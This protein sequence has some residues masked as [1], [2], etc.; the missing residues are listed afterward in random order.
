MSAGCAFETHS[1]GLG[2]GGLDAD[3]LAPSVGDAGVGTGGFDTTTPDTTT[4]DTTTPDTT[5]P[6]TTTPDTTTPDTTTSDTTTPDKL[7]PSISTDVVVVEP[8]CTPGTERSSCPGTSCDPVTLTCTTLMLA[9]RSTCETCFTDSNCAGVDHRCVWMTYQGEPIPDKRMGFCLQ[10]AEPVTV[11]GGYA[12]LP[13]FT[14]PLVNRESPSGGKNQSYCGIHEKL[15]TCFA[16]RAFHNGEA[17]PTGRDDECP[18]GGLCRAIASTG[19]KTE[20][21]CTYACTDVSECSSPGAKV[22]CAGFCGG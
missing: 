7:D 6:D 17:C 14:V 15:T 9:S 8:R 5:T 4:P 16:L 18:T 12:C 19:R 21:T 11:D 20:Y 13:P 10:I 2:N 1:V 22:N 3:G